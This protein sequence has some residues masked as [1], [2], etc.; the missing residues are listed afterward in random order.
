MN[1]IP[2]ISV[3]IPVYNVEK[4]LSRC[5]DS[6]LFQTFADFELLLIDDGTSDHSGQICD[7][8][9][10]RD[11]R[12]RVLH[13]E[14]AGASTAR[15]I[16]ID[17]SQGRYIVFVDSDD[18]VKVD[19]LSNLLLLLP[20]K[21]IGMGFTVQGCERYNEKKEILRATQFIQRLYATNE[22]EEFFIQTRVSWGIF[23]PCA[24]LFERRLLNEYSIRFDTT[25][26][27]AEDIPFILHCMSKCDYMAVGSSLD[28]CYISYSV[29]TVSNRVYPFDVEYHSFVSIKQQVVKVIE[30][31]NF[32]AMGCRYLYAELHFIFS[33][34]L[35]SDYHY[36]NDISSKDRTKH[37]CN[38]ITY[39]SD[40]LKH[41]YFP[42]YLLDKFGRFFLLNGLVSIYDTFFFILVKLKIKKMYAAPLI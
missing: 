13:Q 39:E 34:L 26:R 8:Y 40:Y 14:N 3:I 28:Y 2:T 1:I 27:F 29:D 35:K 20:T 11:D 32:S 5:V 9:A 7:D 17:A 31:C 36:L 15:N 10:N 4:Y 30:E 24:K 33:T 18:Y 19:Y 37:L 16:G 38:I 22:I 25:V 6:I 23:S 21:E 42:D 41:Y 12:I